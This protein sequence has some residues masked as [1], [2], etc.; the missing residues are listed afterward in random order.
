MHSIQVCTEL[1]TS[2]LMAAGRRKSPQRSPR[3]ARSNVILPLN[4]RKQPPPTSLLVPIN[5]NAPSPSRRS[6]PRL[7]KRHLRQ[8]PQRQR[9]ESP[10][11]QRLHPMAELLHAQR[12]P[13]PRTPTETMRMN[14]RTM[15]WTRLTTSLE[16]KSKAGARTIT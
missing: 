5:P 9:Q 10:R 16:T 15:T 2:K 8:H 3:P 11:Q 6:P 13:S 14:F 4:S 12:S 7:Q 1:V